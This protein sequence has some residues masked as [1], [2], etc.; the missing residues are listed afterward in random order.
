MPDRF[1]GFP[2]QA[3]TFY[4][5]LTANNTKPWWTEH[6]GEYETAVRAPLLALVGELEAEFGPARLFRPYRD[7]RFHKG[8]PL[9]T[10]Q[11]AVVSIEDAMGYYVQVGADGL[12]V[13]GGW[14]QASGRQLE[15]FRDAV[16]GPAGATLEALLARLRRSYE[17]NG[18]PVATRPRG[19]PADHPRLELMRMRKVTVAKPHGDADWVHT[20]KALDAVRRDWRAM[21]PVLEWLADHVGPATE[22]GDG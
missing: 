20:R 18:D 22:P 1:T 9:K 3:F 2:A 12:F 21:R 8:E 14:Y 16:D 11:G 19:V 15:R 5:A 7:T 17:V 13:A 4:Q 10:H 6:K